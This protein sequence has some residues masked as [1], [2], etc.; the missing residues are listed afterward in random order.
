MLWQAG[1]PALRSLLHLDGYCGDLHAHGGV[2]PHRPDR[3]GNPGQRRASGGKTD[4][5]IQTT[6][7]AASR[8][9]K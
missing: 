8:A 1:S 5:R 3:R 7:S 9:R 4:N 6:V 2:D